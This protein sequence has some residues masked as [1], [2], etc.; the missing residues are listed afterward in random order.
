MSQSIADIFRK[1]SKAAKVPQ[2]KSHLIE[3]NCDSSANYHTVTES[4]VVVQGKDATNWV[5]NGPGCEVQI[6][7][8][9]KAK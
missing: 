3:P 8:L 5:C 6:D 4:T 9:E 2:L 1:A 7:S